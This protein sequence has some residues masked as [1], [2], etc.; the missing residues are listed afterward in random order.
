L[1]GGEKMEFFENRKSR[2]YIRLWEKKKNVYKY[3]TTRTS[4]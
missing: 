3:T 1:V 4:S 2:D